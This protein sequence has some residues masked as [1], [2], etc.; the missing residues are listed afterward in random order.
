MTTPYE[1]GNPNS[2]I[3]V[4]G[5]TPGYHE[6]R[7]GRPLIGPSGEIFNDILRRSGVLRRDCYIVNMW[8]DPAPFGERVA[9][10]VK[11]DKKSGHVFRGPDMFFHARKGF[12]DI[13]LKAAQPALARIARAKPNVIVP[14]GREAMTLATGKLR[15]MMKWRGSIVEGHAR[16]GKRKVIPTIHPAATLHGVFLW[17]YII[18]RDFEKIRRHAEFPELRLPDRNLIVM[19][20]YDEAMDYLAECR[21]AK[22]V[23]TDLEVINH[24]VHC[25]SLCFDPMEA[26]SIPLVT[27]RGNDY[28]T[29]DQELDIWTAY[30]ELMADENV[31]KVNQALIFFDAPFLLQQNNIYTKG[32]LGDTMLAQQI[33]YPDFNKGLDFICS[34][35]TDEPY[36]KDEGKMW[37]GVGGDIV[38]FWRYNAKDAATALES[39]HVLRDE[40]EESGYWE[41]YEMTAR[42]SNPLMYMTLRGFKVDKARLEQTKKDVDNALKGKEADL[43][44]VADF[45]F[46]PGSSQQTAR[47]FYIHKGL[48]PYKNAQGGITTDDKAMARIYRKHNMPEAKLVQEIRAMRK[49]KST[50]M[51]VVL[52][53]DYRLRCSWGR[54]STGRLTSSKTIFG[55]GMNQ[56]NLHPQFKPFLVADNDK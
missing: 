28:W 25:F 39:W 50:Y 36:Y 5:E 10:Q 7:N 41:T 20:T 48:R 42:M 14:L 40:M 35:Y 9:Y 4:I 30:A 16:V 24:Q 33:M 29:E 3:L 52:D 46:N 23:A 6:I 8:G 11:K 12:T 17:R 1:E 54:A 15:P 56:Q 53:T 27:D 38:E 26:M 49:L 34:I 32:F 37:R 44:R 19:P 47:Y 31:A 51:E 43:E 18:E 55:T 13:G 45:P 2:K 21:K 22:E